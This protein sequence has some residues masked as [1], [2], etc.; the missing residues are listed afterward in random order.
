MC[1]IFVLSILVWVIIVFIDGEAVIS[2]QQRGLRHSSDLLKIIAS[3]V[4]LDCDAWED[5]AARECAAEAG[6]ED[7][8]Y[9]KAR[10]AYIACHHSTAWFAVGESFAIFSARLR[11]YC[12]FERIATRDCVTAACANYVHQ[13]DNWAPTY[14][15]SK[16]LVRI[17]R[18]LLNCHIWVTCIY[19][20]HTVFIWTV[21]YGLLVY[22][23]L[24]TVFI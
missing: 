7:N 15:V 10:V 22:I 12:D 6:R 24:H 5:P 18:C 19:Y 1:S 13:R 17:R 21:T 9:L 20:L 2:D 8:K 11:E 23:Y 4:S 16:R 14:L 3:C